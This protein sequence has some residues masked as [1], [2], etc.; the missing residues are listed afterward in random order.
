M[1]VPTT[2]QPTAFWIALAGLFAIAMLRGQGT[3]WLARLV[4][5]GS[6]RVTENSRP[7]RLRVAAWLDGPRVA[8]GRR[9][10]GRWGLP[11]I[12]IC[13]LTVGLQTIILAS[14]GLLRVGWVRFT[15]AQLP[16]AIAWAWIYST[17]GIAAFEALLGAA[18]SSPLG[19]AVIAAVAVV[20]IATIV[21]RRRAR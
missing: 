14:A 11:L 10:L 13:Y 4:A 21:V 8:V 20:V 1:P 6:T 15:L 5:H 7:W 19:I 3:Y 16:G 18:I 9:L 17:I 12:T 2:T